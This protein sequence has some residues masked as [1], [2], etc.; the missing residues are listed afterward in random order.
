MKRSAAF[1]LLATFLFS[2]FLRLLPLTKHLFWGADIG[3]YYYISEQLVANGYV[4][5]TYSGWGFAY[6]YFPGMEIVVASSSLLGMELSMAMSLM[7][8]VLASII[9][10]PVFLI[11]IEITRSD[12]AALIAAAFLAVAMPHVYATS[13]PMP[14]AIGDLLFAVC[15]LLFLKWLRHPKFGLLLFPATLALIVTHHLST[16]FLLI[17]LTSGIL[18]VQLLRNRTSAQRLTREVVYVLF[19]VIVAISY[20]FVGSPGFIETVTSGE[21]I[22]SPIL[23]ALL[24]V[25]LA[26]AILVVC[27]R[28]RL[29]PSL[30]FRYPTHGRALAVYVLVLA[31]GF[32]IL[33]VSVLVVVPGTNVNLP[34]IAVLLFLPFILFIAFTGPGSRPISFRHRGLYPLAWILVIALSTLIGVFTSSRVLIPYRHMEYLMFPLSILIGVG[35]IH[36]FGLVHLPRSGARTG[37]AIT[38]VLGLVTTNA[39]I[40]FP[41]RDVIAGYEEGTSPKAVSLAY[42]SSGRVDDLVAADHRVSSVLFGFGDVDATWDTARLVFHSPDFEGARV[43]LENLDSPSRRRTVRFVALD[44]DTIDGVLLYTWNPAEA[45]SEEAVSK[46]EESPF[47]KLYDDG[48]SKLFFLNWGL[49]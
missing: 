23:I 42:W 29:I 7:V 8:P 1:A 24:L 49:A 46:F 45:M 3:E 44:L 9:V 33:L 28:R 4:S 35:F 18:L 31:T 21:P 32:L 17:S 36:A 38:V 26:I 48:Y 27:S 20:W 39:M 14:A 30:V 11:T 47:Q 13:H 15:L 16:Y 34:A 10:F 37:I 12:R 41:P 43:E 22:F 2:M 25:A 6:P 40:A 19:T 5:E